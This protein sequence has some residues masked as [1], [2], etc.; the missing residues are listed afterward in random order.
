LWA[1]V[2]MPEAATRR[3]SVLG[4]RHQTEADALRG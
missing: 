1:P 3:I 2:G 4:R